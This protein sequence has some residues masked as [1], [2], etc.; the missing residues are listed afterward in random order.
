MLK[1]RNNTGTKEYVSLQYTDICLSGYI[2]IESG[3]CAT[4]INASYC[5]VAELQINFILL[6]SLC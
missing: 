6:Y 3:R 2:I 4:N 1:S 5:C